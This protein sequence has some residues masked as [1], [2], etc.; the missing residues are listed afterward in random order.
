MKNAQTFFG[1]TSDRAAAMPGRLAGRGAALTALLL[2]ASLLLFAGCRNAILP[3]SAEEARS[4]ESAEG[5]G[6]LSL[7][8]SQG[9]AATARAL[10]A[11]IGAEIEIE[12]FD[13]FVF[14]L[15]LSHEN[16]VNNPLPIRSWDGGPVG[17]LAAGQ[18]TLSITA[19][20]P[21]P[22]GGAPLAAAQTS[23]PVS[24][25][26]NPG[27]ITSV[28]VVELVP[29][30]GG[31]GR[32]SWDLSL[33]PGGSAQL[34]VAHLVSGSSVVNVFFYDDNSDEYLLPAGQ[35]RAYL[36]LSHEGESITLSRILNIYAGL[37]S[38]WAETFTPEHFHR[39]F[40]DY[41]LGLWDGS[42]WGD[43]S[44]FID[45]H[46]DILREDVGGIEGVDA[47]N[48]GAVFHY[49]LNAITRL[50]AHPGYFGANCLRTLVDAAL[51]ALE[52]QNIL[53]ISQPADAEAAIRGLAANGASM[54]FAWSG[55]AVV[56]TIGGVYSVAV[57]VV[58]SREN[59]FIR[60]D[61]GTFLMGYCPSGASETP[62]RYVTVSGFYMSR[63][64]ITQG[65]WYDVMYHL[66]GTGVG[67][68]RPSF[69]DGTNN[70]AGTTVTPTFD[71]RSLP[72]ERVS[73]YEVLVFANRLSIM[74]GLSPAYSINGSTNPAD[75]GPVPPTP[76]AT[77]DNVEIVSGSTGYRL[78]TEAQW[79]FA[80]RG[81][82]VCQGNFVFSGSNT[83]DD[84]AWSRDNSGG[85]TREVGT[86]RPNALGLYDMSG[87]V[88]EWVWDWFGSYPNF[89]ETDPTGAAAGDARVVRSGGWSVAPG[90][91]RSAT[92]SLTGPGSRGN[93]LG[94]RV[95][96]PIPGN[97][98]QPGTPE[99]EMRRVA[100]GTFL[101][102]SPEGTPDSRDDER[103]VR[104]VTLTGFYMGRFPVT[105]GEW[106]DVMY[107]LPG[108][109]VG[110]RRPSFFDGTNN[111]NGTTVTPTFDWRSLPVEMV[112]WYD[113][114]VFANRL[115]IMRGLS[116][117]YSI[118]G[119]T[120]PADW[121]PVPLG[122]DAAWDAV[123]MVPGSTGY[124]LPTEAQWEFAA[125]G[126]I[127]CQGN[128]VFS[129]SNTA[130]DVAWHN[131]NSGGRT[132][133]VGTLRPNALGLYDMSGNVW[134]WVWDWRGLYPNFPEIDPTG[135]A[136]GVV[137][138]NR[139]GSWVNS[140]EFARSA[141]RNDGSLDS[142]SRNFGFRVVRP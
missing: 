26:V 81:G 119:S 25:W 42:S 23:A 5:T 8:I 134:E 36:A 80:A 86:L 121:G 79:E 63:F 104:Q 64:P 69:F 12:G 62:L 50:P 82:I 114:L 102:G 93:F 44:W 47:D 67:T 125:R 45:G 24:F 108:T 32:F 111:L 132:R 65:E 9:R 11:A 33:P 100:G 19:L 55:N 73:W 17:S 15:Y 77:W 115:S 48:I 76:D 103:P 2:A 130:D 112:R 27:G 70:S 139:G 107:H 35:Y 95:V 66:P 116:P 52:A 109:G 94:F 101:M 117:A 110:T 34:T 43:L 84:V 20:L 54:A 127:V 85:R 60:V 129:G 72:V 46:F 83:A 87:N 40:L 91:A 74:R 16:P 90:I 140:P 14:D 106:Y 56:V 89:P 105:Q 118:N 142:R 30:S 120:N 18:W 37:T 58:S 1:M 88:L 39:S 49:W 29:I 13:Y 41:F 133:E 10:G 99:I 131:G 61:G 7:T 98:P 4:S 68:Q 128:F 53:N 75:W 38:R 57:S 3:P 137:R 22:A 126:G 78:P 96:R 124:R 97:V 28:V 123:V 71:R 138:V 6:Y 113:A 141:L 51:V 31:Y 135:A 21:D 92:R 59:Y 122:R 136:A